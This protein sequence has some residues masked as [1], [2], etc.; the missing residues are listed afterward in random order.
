MENIQGLAENRNKIMA[1]L[2]D[3]DSNFDIK[4]AMI[5][6][7]MSN[8]IP[9]VLFLYEKSRMYKQ[10]LTHFIQRKDSDGVMQTCRKFADKECPQLWVDSLQYFAEI[11]N[12]EQKANIATVLESKL[13]G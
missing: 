10:I 13:F 3:P 6:C 9:G 11:Y 12:Q 8:F 7:Q 4:K 1:F 2:Q 5:L